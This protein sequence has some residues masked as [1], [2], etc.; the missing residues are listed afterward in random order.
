M[1][2]SAVSPKQ[3]EPS[4]EE[5]LAS[6]RRIIS[7]DQESGRIAPQPE[8]ARADKPAPLS[9]SARP[10]NIDEDDSV[11]IDP[12]VASAPAD[13]APNAAP[14]NSS[15]HE[16][17]TSDDAALTLA[18]FDAADLEEPAE[19]EPLPR[20][21]EEM[22]VDLQSEPVHAYEP[23]FPAEEHQPSPRAPQP[24]KEDHLISAATDH[25]VSH[26][27]N[28]LTHTVLSQNARTLEDLVKDMLRPM[29]KNWLDENLPVMVERL[30]RAEIERVARG[31]R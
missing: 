21:Q 3:P 16:E 17:V 27:F 5:I 28:L 6:I 1:Q 11:D 24:A 14:D 18:E 29:L 15:K 20:S 13:S 26:A 7:D 12:S 8:P 2:M 10:L 22:T 31:G 30:V 23:E 25:S 4:M 19:P 9:P